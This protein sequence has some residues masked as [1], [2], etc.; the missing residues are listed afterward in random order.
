MRKKERRAAAD[1]AAATATAR[2]RLAWEREEEEVAIGGGVGGSSLVGF[3]CVKRSNGDGKNKGD[4][5]FHTPFFSFRTKGRN[6]REAVTRS[7]AWFLVCYCR[8]IRGFYIVNKN[9]FRLFG[10]LNC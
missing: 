3:F 10:V 9:T 8:R 2:P 6:V 5:I 7:P 4:A 1:E